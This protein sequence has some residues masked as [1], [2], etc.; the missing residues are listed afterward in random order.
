MS[1]SNFSQI[2]SLSAPSL[3]PVTDSLSLSASQGVLKELMEGMGWRDISGSVREYESQ[4][5]EDK[6]S[7]QAA[8]ER[9]ESDQNLE[10]ANQLLSVLD[11]HLVA[12]KK[13]RQRALEE[14]RHYK[15]EAEK[16]AV[17]LAES[18]SSSTWTQWFQ[19]GIGRIRHFFD[20]T[21]K[22]LE[23]KYANIAKT[24]QDQINQA[25]I[26]RKQLHQTLKAD[27]L[28]GKSFSSS[29]KKSKLDKT[30]N[31]FRLQNVP[32]ISQSECQS[33]RIPYGYDPIV[34]LSAPFSDLETKLTNANNIDN[35]FVASS[36]NQIVIAWNTKASS[37]LSSSTIQATQIYENT[38]QFNNF[39]FDPQPSSNQTHPVVSVFRN[40][41][42]VIA[43]D[44]DNGSSK[45]IFA[46]CFSATGS[47]GLEFQVNDIT[48][49]GSHG[50][51]AVATLGDF[52]AIAWSYMV[53]QSSNT[54]FAR[55]YQASIN[56]V[57][58]TISC[59]NSFAITGDVEIA[60]YA[61]YALYDSPDITVTYDQNGIG[62][63]YFAWAGNNSY[64]YI[65]PFSMQGIPLRAGY[66]T[67]AFRVSSRSRPSVRGSDEQLIAAWQA[68]DPPSDF[69][70][71]AQPISAVG[72]E[73]NLGFPAQPVTPIATSLANETHVVLE[74]F[75][76]GNF[77]VV[78]QVSNSTDDTG[79]FETY[80]C[81]TALYA[82]FFQDIQTPLTDW[83]C[84][85]GNDV[86]Q[87]KPNIDVFLN[88]DFVLV[89]V[90]QNNHLNLLYYSNQPPYW[91]TSNSTG[92]LVSDGV[93][94]LSITE[95]E[96]S[97]WSFS[98]SD[99]LNSYDDAG[100][101]KDPEGGT[102]IC[103]ATII[104][105]PLD[106]G[107]LFDNK[108]IPLPESLQLSQSDCV[109]GSQG[110]TKSQI[111]ICI[112]ASDLEGS[113][114]S[115]LLLRLNV[116]P[117]PK[118]PWYKEPDFQ[119]SIG[120]I[121]SIIGSVLLSILTYQWRQYQLKQHREFQHPFASEVHGWLNLA[122]PDFTSGPGQDF[123]RI[124]TMILQ[125]IKN[126]PSGIDIP[127]RDRI[128]EVVEDKESASLMMTIEDLD[129]RK[130]S[131]ERTD[132]TLSSE[133]LYKE[134][135]SQIRYYCYAV[136]VAK[137]IYMTPGLL[138]P[139]QVCGVQLRWFLASNEIQM[140]QFELQAENIVR[141][142]SKEIKQ[143]PAELELK[144][145]KLSEVKKSGWVGWAENCRSTLVRDEE[146]DQ[147][148]SG[149]EKACCGPLRNSWH[150][151]RVENQYTLFRKDERERLKKYPIQYPNIPDQR[152]S[153]APKPSGEAKYTENP[154]RF[155]SSPS[156]SGRRDSQHDDFELREITP[157]PSDQPEHR[158]SLTVS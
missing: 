158:D 52:F 123:A 85:P 45:N 108:P 47:P 105:T 29:S 114:S 39:V 13:E 30:R 112:T 37:R 99:H 7:L 62:T 102:V 34:N 11:D 107:C 80:F 118:I 8:V 116:I 66:E 97:S 147:E 127:E 50:Y 152:K 87:S 41:Q 93:Y 157:P 143:L 89:A 88:G 2:S 36:Y 94:S 12:L 43:W 19:Q 58:N 25:L 26:Y 61:G 154:S 86:V 56:Y 101:V 145:P 21:P 64:L 115:P 28:P 4:Y 90:D 23:E 17:I 20:S 60:S 46:K 146:S 119:K 70:I 27:L 67:G 129:M 55:F 49:N 137:A 148:R 79:C 109:L 122:Y 117:T 151:F 65:R 96:G 132:K 84:I 74:V 35:P 139:T 149:I 10:T 75:T 95:Y 9:Y 6:L 142:V 72:L 128:R 44:T 53:N 77:V 16:E 51:P 130:K 33:E 110:L 59:N 78:W 150:D 31:K 131:A 103:S 81:P 40:Q 38:E 133:E 141:K 98:L 63:Y 3:S 120:T 134:L 113:S 54:M 126:P 68:Y 104:N 111:N 5:Q 24:C 140:S 136:C 106:Y 76:G 156:V 91:N 22:Q 144:S 92:L 32:T 69:D 155:M 125:I 71:Y 18:P 121:A 100:I 153:D 73:D 14:Q 15:A 42:V 135:Y 48:Q 82:R 83:Y 124:I 138:K 1:R 57:D